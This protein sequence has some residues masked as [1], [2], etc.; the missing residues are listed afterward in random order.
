MIMNADA[1]NG[2][3]PED[4]KIFTE[5]WSK[6][7]VMAAEESNKESANGPKSVSGSGGKIRRP[8]AAEMVEWRK[9][10]NPVVQE[11][12]KTAKSNNAKDPEAILAEWQRQIDAYQE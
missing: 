1:W 9:A 4:Q 6:A 5:L 3:S 8:V 2:M 12:I 7:Y 11:W 10:A